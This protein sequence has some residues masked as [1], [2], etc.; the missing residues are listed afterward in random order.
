[1]PSLST[2]QVIS[3]IHELSAD[4]NVEQLIDRNSMTWRHDML[5][6]VFMPWDVE[7][8]MKIPLSSRCPRD[9]IIWIEPSVKSAY[10]MLLSK[11]S[12]QEP[13]SSSSWG[14]DSKL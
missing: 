1:M 11:C 12:S 8:I 4:A 2:Y 6:Q 13:S 9:S 10:C 5:N 7:I 3:L 14:M